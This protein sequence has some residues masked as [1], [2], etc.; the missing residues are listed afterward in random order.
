MGQQN[1]EI[2]SKRTALSVEEKK[3]IFDQSKYKSFVK[4]SRLEGIKVIPVNN[5]INELVNKY[6]IIGAN[7]NGR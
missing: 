4:S 2:K 3:K 6:E 7:A 5:T 1:G